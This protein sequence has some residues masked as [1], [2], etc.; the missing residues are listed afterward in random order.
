V[1]LSFPIDAWDNNVAMMLLSVAGN[2]CAMSPK[3]RLLDVAFPDKLLANFKGPK[4]GVPGIRE[5]TGIYDR[6]LSLHII[7]PKMGMTP[8]QTADQCYQTA[9]GGVD[10]IKDDEMCT[11]VYNCRYDERLRA[12]LETL[13]KA[14]DKTGKKPIYFLSIT[15]EPPR[16][17]E[18]AAHAV[19]LGAQG[20]LVCYSAG[21]PVIRR[22]AEDTAIDVPILIHAA[23]M[24]AAQPRIS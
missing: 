22:L 23:H 11:D 1:Q 13:D 24:V 14:A 21:L 15:D 2:W 6:P 17:F 12:V 5:R 9:L 7:K 19:E 8:Q 3:S 16:I 20:L 10:M 18:K 4:F